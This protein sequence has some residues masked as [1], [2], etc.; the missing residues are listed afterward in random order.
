MADVDSDD[1]I[2]ASCDL[3]QK[4]EISVTNNDTDGRID[5]N[6]VLNQVR[7]EL[8][9]WRN[10]TSNQGFC[11]STRFGKCIGMQSMHQVESIL[12]GTEK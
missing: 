1:M 11:S 5:Y 12:I 4:Y 3:K 10:N 6:Q 8:I 2:R 9:K 7:F